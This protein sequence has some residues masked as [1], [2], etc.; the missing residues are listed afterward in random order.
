MVVLM[1]QIKVNS[2]LA[3]FNLPVA[4]QDTAKTQEEALKISKKIGFPVVMK[5]VSP[6]I[7]H[8]TEAGAIKVDIK[9]EQEAKTA[10]SE[11]IANSKKYNK[12]A[13]I[14]GVLIQEMM[15]GQEVIVGMKNDA[16]FGQVIM[17][18]LGGVL[19]ELIK[20]VSFR[21]APVDRK[22]ALE[23]LKELKSY[24]LLDGFRGAKKANINA[25]V[26]II[27]KTSDLVLK[28]KDIVELDFNPVIVNEKNAKIVDVRIMTK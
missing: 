3:R 17:V 15:Q 23:M 27:V 14:Q 10:F 18:G 20:D 28:N 1:E 22:M 16:Q 24:N 12:N 6:E 9:N 11:I 2:L 25:V 5:I 19:V 7:V 26:D 21:I 8:K 4:K 13:K